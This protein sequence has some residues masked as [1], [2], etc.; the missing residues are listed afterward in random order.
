[1]LPPKEQVARALLMRGTVFL[2]LDPRR[3]DVQAPSWLRNDPQLVLQIGLDMPVPIPDLR[4]DRRG[5]SGT[6][7][8]DD[9]SHLCVVS[10][11]AIYAIIGEDGKGLVWPE[12]MPEELTRE[13]RKEQLAGRGSE[14]ARGASRDREPNMQ[15]PEWRSAATKQP[16]FH[17]VKSETKQDQPPDRTRR[18]RTRQLEDGKARPPRKASRELPPYLRVVK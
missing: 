4:V 8:F 1:M 10:W 15:K 6:L 16:V 2:H 5:F 3:S 14:P 13:V 12:S 18:P 7:A 9:V 17:C 11:E